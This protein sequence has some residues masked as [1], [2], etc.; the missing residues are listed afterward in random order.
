MAAA[1]PVRRLAGPIAVLVLLPVGTACL[2]AQSRSEFVDLVRDR[3]GGVSAAVV[4]DVRAALLERVGTDDPDV[5]DVVFDFDSSTAVVEVRNPAR[6]RELDLYTFRH[7]DVVAVDPVRLDTDDDL[8]ATTMP[9][10]A[11]GFDQVERVADTALD[12]WA[13][14]DGYVA[15][16]GVTSR[17]EPVLLR[18]Q[19]ESPRASA[20]ADF[21]TGGE[22]VELRR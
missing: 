14:S 6:P 16:M 19:L 15:S 8:D 17:V 11:T 9:F 1:G 10:S 21:T 5:R 2:G 20:S 4:D 22:L 13:V 7:G 18:V 3:G 12:R